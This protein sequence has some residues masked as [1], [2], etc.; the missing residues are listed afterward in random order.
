MNGIGLRSA[1]YREFLETRPP[2]DFVE[3]HSENYFGRDA[4]GIGGQ[5]RAVLDA[6]R[7]DYPISLHGIGLSLG[8][9]ERLDLAHLRQLKILVDRYQPIRVSD[10]LAWVGVDGVYLN[11]LLPLPY[12]EEAFAV[13]ARNVAN[14]Q[15]YLSRQL[16]IENPSRYIDFTQSTLSE[17]EFLNRLARDTGCGILLDI[18][19][20]F[21]SA[22]NLKFDALAY[23]RDI[24][25]DTVGEI[26]LAGFTRQDDLLIDTHNRPVATEV[27]NLFAETLALA[28]Y[29]GSIPTLIEWDTDQ[30]ALSVLIE[31]SETA[32]RIKTIAAE[33]THVDLA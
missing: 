10:H 14:V 8:S 21:V 15:D 33:Q 11:D 30:P 25:M 22:H 29:A 7:A 1:H 27:W 2:V 28:P 17:V 6:V 16:L 12:T 26:H 24:D 31:E 20:V 3:V 5:P 4:R 23:A 19:N 9:D 32:R 18:N 13:V